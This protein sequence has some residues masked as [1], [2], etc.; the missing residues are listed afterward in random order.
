MST[1]NEIITAAFTRRGINLA[2]R[3][4]YRVFVPERLACEGTQ[5]IT[6]SLSAWTGRYFHEVRA[7]I[8]V[9][10]LGIAVRSIAPHVE[11][12]LSDPA[13][14][15]IDESGRFVI[16]VLSGHIGGA[17][18]LARVIAD[19]IHAQAVITTAT[20]VNNIIAVDEWSVKNECV[21]ENPENIK[22]IS[23]SMLEGHNVGVAVTCDNIPVP[24]P[25]TLWLRPKVLVLGAGCHKGVSESEFER[26]VR[27]FLDGAGVS[28]LSLRAIAS[29]D[30]KAHE[31]ALIS[32][33]EKHNIPFV[34]F[35]AD[36]LNAL[37]G[38][39]SGSAIV[40]SITGTDNICERACMLAAG[41]CAVLLRSKCVYDNMTFALARIRRNKLT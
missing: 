11:S 23:G 29:I 17:N 38:K 36:E 16:P 41:E 22:Y 40:K 18:E 34:T 31:P 20:D 3:L 2:L 12:K 26:S 37:P 28:I 8:F 21:I 13:V 24:F 19:K 30:I 4:G 32:F 9:G 27:D 14:I 7:L 1:E 25:V 15:V 6:E 35:S 39:F 5:A 33:A 10:A